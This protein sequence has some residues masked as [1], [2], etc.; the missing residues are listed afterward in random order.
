M[1]LSYAMPLLKLMSEKKSGELVLSPPFAYTTLRFYV[2]LKLHGHC[3]LHTPEGKLTLINAL[4]NG[5]RLRMTATNF[6]LRNEHPLLCFVYLVCHLSH[7][8]K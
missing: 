3:V 5:K 6:I 1:G 7:S 2:V 4:I 8:D